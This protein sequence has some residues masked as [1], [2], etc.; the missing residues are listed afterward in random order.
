MN[1]HSTTII[2]FPKF[3]R[4]YP[5][6]PNLRMKF[7]CRGNYSHPHSPRSFVPELTF[8][9][10]YSILKKCYPFGLIELHY[11]KIFKMNKI[12]FSFSQEHKYSKVN[13]RM[14]RVTLLFIFIFFHQKRSTRILGITYP[15]HFAVV[16]MIS[17]WTHEPWYGYYDFYPAPTYFQ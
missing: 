10:R 13:N 11:L 6:L 17:Y 5:K 12:N 14:W 15:G 2:Q 16:C 7:G 9:K 4:I 3:R 1:S 8:G